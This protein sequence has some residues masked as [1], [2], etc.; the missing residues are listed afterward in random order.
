MIAHDPHWVAKVV[1]DR[2]RQSPLGQRL[3]VLAEDVRQETTDG[4]W[5]YVPVSIHR[6]PERM[7][8]I[9]DMLSELEEQLEEDEVP[10][11]LVPRIMPFERWQ[12]IA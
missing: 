11:L 6:D 12:D 3:R 7:A 10:V 4:V 9:Y 8:E 1:Q 5:W 2:L